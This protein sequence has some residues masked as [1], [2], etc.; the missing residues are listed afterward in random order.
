MFNLTIVQVTS[1]DSKVDDS[2]DKNQ[3]CTT[4]GAHMQSSNRYVNS[5]ISPGLSQHSIF[6]RFTWAPVDTCGQ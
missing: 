2:H 5:S 3:R 1:L 4:V 6:E